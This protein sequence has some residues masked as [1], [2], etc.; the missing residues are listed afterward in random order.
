MPSRAELF[1]AIDNGRELAQRDFAV[2]AAQGHLD[3]VAG[4]PPATCDTFLT[5]A[6]RRGR[7]DVIGMLLQMGASVD[8]PLQGR[9]TPLMLASGLNYPDAAL[10][11]LA[12]GARATGLALQYALFCGHLRC[13]QIL[14]SYGA[15]RTVT[16]P[17]LDLSEYAFRYG[18]PELAAW[19]AESD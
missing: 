2:H 15:P 5:R 11:L 4:V 13:F 10:A 17:Y 8:Q 6:A 1:H 14:S 3:D 18:T 7:T 9:V 16:S 12:A 19:V